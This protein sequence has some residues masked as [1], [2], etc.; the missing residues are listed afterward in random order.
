MKKVHYFSSIAS[1]CLL[2]A[3]A[4]A[5]EEED[6]LSIEIELGAIFTSG[7][8][9]DENIQFRGEVNWLQDTLEYGFSV[10]GFRSSKDDVLSAQRVYYVA[11]VNYEFTENS[12]ILTRL[13]HEDDRFSGYDGQTDI[14]VN[15]GRNFLTNRSNMAMIFNIGLGARKSRSEEEDFDEAIIRLA[16]DYDWNISE[17]ATFNQQLSTESGNETSIYR[18]ESSIET[19]I[20][21]NLLLRL[22][23]NVKHQTEVPAG[24]EKTDT[25]MSLTFVMNF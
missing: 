6:G 1:I 10:D 9:E 25:E 16:V 22:S 8:T 3:A 13:A 18:S 17:S 23:F 15:Y 14:S 11:S 4:N 5:Q 24:R 2:C 19:Q 12:F 7:N 20:L 21:E